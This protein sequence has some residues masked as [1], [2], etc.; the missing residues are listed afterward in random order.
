[1][2]IQVH[3]KWKNNQIFNYLCGSHHWIRPSAWPTTVPGPIKQ[4]NNPG[5]GPT[6]WAPLSAAEAGARTAAL[7]RRR[8]LVQRRI[9]PAIMDRNRV[10]LLRTRARGFSCVARGQGCTGASCWT[11]AGLW[12]LFRLSSPA[13]T[14][15]ARAKP[16]F[17][18]FINVIQWSEKH[19][20]FQSPEKTYP[21]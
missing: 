18:L 6:G 13:T 15:E 5:L 19:E 2:H 10:W 11:A 1:M 17:F 4:Q 3:M 21:N 14:T 16:N 12:V 9:C 20:S 7:V 8:A